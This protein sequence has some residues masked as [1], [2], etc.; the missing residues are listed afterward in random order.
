M[1]VYFHYFLDN[2][3][4][5]DSMLKN[6]LLLLIFIQIFFARVI[7]AQEENKDD[8]ENYQSQP[9]V[10]QNRFFPMRSDGI[11]NEQ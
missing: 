11:D 2:W 1:S 4:Q 8:E 6:F 3:E 7:F 10:S 5:S 9:V